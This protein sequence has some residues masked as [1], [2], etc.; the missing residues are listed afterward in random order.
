[1][2]GSDAVEQALAK[3]RDYVMAETL[4]I[5]WAVDQADALYSSDKDLGDQHWTIEIS[6]A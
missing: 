3:H 4:A 6:K 1:V 2:S 5:E